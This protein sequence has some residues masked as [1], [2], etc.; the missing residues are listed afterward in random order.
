MEN[1]RIW[2]KVSNPPA[3]ALK[4]IGGG[5]LK[6]MTD[7]NPQWRLEAMTELFGPIG[8]DW[9]YTIDKLWREDGAH[10]E[11]FAFALVSVWYIEESKSESI[12]GVGGSKLVTKEKDGLFSSDE[13]YKMAVT[14]ALSVALKALG[15]GSAIYQGK[16]DGSKYKDSDVKVEKAKGDFKAVIKSLNECKALEEVNRLAVELMKL[17]WSQDETL[18]LKNEFSAKRGSLETA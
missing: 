17:E 11:V 7:I 3:T 1:K 13:G 6:G 9:G 4:Q 8:Q 14:D 12:Q 2:S 16:W 5:R 10:D 15:V 18:K